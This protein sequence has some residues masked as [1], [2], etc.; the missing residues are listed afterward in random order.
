MSGRRL[1]LGAAVLLL[2]SIAIWG[3]ST[4]LSGSSQS[5]PGKP[6]VVS[7]EGNLATTLDAANVGVLVALER[8][9]AS[10]S[11]VRT[12]VGPGSF[13]QR[14]V[15]RADRA[16]AQK[17]AGLRRNGLS[18]RQALNE[19][20]VR[21][22]YMGAPSID[23]ESF[24]GQLILGSGTRPERRL[25]WLF[26]NDNHALLLVRPRPGLDVARTRALANRVRHLAA[27]APLQGVQPHLAVVPLA[28]GG[29]ARDLLGIVL[30]V[31]GAVALGLLVWSRRRLLL[32]PLYSPRSVPS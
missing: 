15:G 12:V 23:N 14:A 11:G 18:A 32:R 6:I 4:P 9:I 25:A 5:E 2:A 27:T 30:A 24:V 10:L 16:I 13:I 20:L 17:V 31:I 26:P 19:L 29:L 7:L 28:S 22:G 1:T 21:Y 3:L 8:R